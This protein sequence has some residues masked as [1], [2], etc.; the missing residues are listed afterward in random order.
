MELA[1]SVKHNEGKSTTLG[2]DLQHIGK[3][4]AYTL[5]TDTKF[6]NFKRNKATASLSVTHMGDAVTAG[7]KVEDKLIVTRRVQVVMSGGAIAGSGDVAYGGSLEATLRDKDF[8]LGRFLTT[9]SVSLMDWHGDLATG[10]N[11][12]TQIPIGRLTNL[13]GSVNFNNRGQGQVSIRL[14]S[15]EHLQI[16]LVALVPLFR[17]LLG[18]PQQLQFEY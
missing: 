18:Y 8:P 6:S 14:N 4:I 12:Q 15:S 1:A 11:A 13:I 3:D 17:K 2:L 10:W 16:A 5:R 9:L 7:V